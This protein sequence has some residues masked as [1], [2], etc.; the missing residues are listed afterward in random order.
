MAGCEGADEDFNPHLGLG[1]GQLLEV[2]TELLRSLAPLEGLSREGAV[3][4]LVEDI[5]S[6]QHEAGR[7]AVGVIE[8]YAALRRCV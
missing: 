2:F 5:S 3:R 1:V 6:H 7:D 4:A 8:D